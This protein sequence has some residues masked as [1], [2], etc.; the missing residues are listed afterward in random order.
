[1][2]GQCSYIVVAHLLIKNTFENKER[3]QLKLHKTIKQMQRLKRKIGAQW[4][5][6]R[7]LDHFP[8]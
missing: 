5:F 4:Y 3:L 7:L 6:A 2:N 1:M 8:L